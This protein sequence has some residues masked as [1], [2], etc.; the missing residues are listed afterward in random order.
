MVDFE[1]KTFS[2]SSRY[3]VKI[4]FF[5]NTKLELE[6]LKKSLSET[7]MDKESLLQR[8]KIVSFIDIY[9]KPRFIY[10]YMHVVPS[11]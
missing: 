4:F 8:L 5:Q 3:S 2:L 10:Y 7:K 9:C 6:E 11:W 1:T